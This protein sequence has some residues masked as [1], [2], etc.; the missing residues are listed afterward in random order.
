MKE[1]LITNISTL[2]D[3]INETL[4][5]FDDIKTT[6]TKKGVAVP[7]GTPVSKY[8]EKIEEVFNAGAQ[9]ICDVVNPKIV[10]ETER[11]NNN[12][13]G[14]AYDRAFEAG[15]K[16]EYD[17]F[18]DGQLEG[19]TSSLVG[20]FSG[21][22]W[23]AKTFKPNQS[24]HCS[25]NI[26]N[27]FYCN[28]YNGDL[29]DIFESRGLEITFKNI[30]SANSAFNNTFFTRVPVIEFASGVSIASTFSNSY[31][32]ETID[33]IVID[34]TNTFS[35]A[36]T[37]CLKLM[38]ITIMG[39]IGNNGFNVTWSP[40][41]KLSLISII[42]ALSTTTTGLTVTLRLS[43]VNTAFETSPGAADGSTSDE[44]LALAATK[45]N[46]TISLINP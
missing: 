2:Q 39:T 12:V 11:L 44:W 28:G 19:T 46:W 3:T 41:S 21:R 33:G 32:L 45:P 31:D 7:D 40:L 25:G 10:E 14:A 6:I 38:N 23:N 30:V 35:N 5:T 9:E 1:N 20:Y 26:I 18:W 37:L 13:S 4:V 17:A 22:G 29:V 15:R 43:A 34:Q 42:N 8:S 16:A 27:M 24:L 36:F